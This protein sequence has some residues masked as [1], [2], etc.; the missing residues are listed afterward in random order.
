MWFFVFYYGMP[1]I[2][3]CNNHQG[4]KSL[5]LHWMHYNFPKH[6]S[7][8]SKVDVMKFLASLLACTFQC[9]WE[10]IARQDPWT[11]EILGCMIVDTAPVEDNKN[12]SCS[13][14]YTLGSAVW[15]CQNQHGLQFMRS[16]IWLRIS[17]GV[18]ISFSALRDIFTDVVVIGRQ[19]THLECV[20][21]LSEQF[22]RSISFMQSDFQCT[23]NPAGKRNTGNA[24]FPTNPGKLGFRCTKLHVWS[25]GNGKSLNVSFLSP[26]PTM[27]LL[28]KKHCI[29]T[30]L[31]MQLMAL[32]SQDFP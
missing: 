19:S 1:T 32:P 30:F 8:S 7:K 2:G 14:V 13:L 22:W 10:E 29:I 9:L 11:V 18:S 23:Q 4:P 15:E 25:H 31:H 6:F 24:C 12:S 21:R 17:V 16:Y 20:M 28:S 27:K 5:L 3:I 26:C